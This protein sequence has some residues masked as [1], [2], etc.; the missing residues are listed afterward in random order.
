MPLYAY[1]FTGRYNDELITFHAIAES[2]AEAEQII[3]PSVE[4]YG[5]IEFWNNAVHLMLPARIEFYPYQVHK[6]SVVR[7]LFAFAGGC[8]CMV[9]NGEHE[10]QRCGKVWME[11]GNY[12]NAIIYQ[13]DHFIYPTVQYYFRAGEHSHM[14]CAEDVLDAWHHLMEYDKTL[15]LPSVFR[16]E[17][18]TAFHQD[19]TNLGCLRWSEW[20]NECLKKK[21]GKINWRAH[22]S[23]SGDII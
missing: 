2:L 23:K 8:I 14:E 18:I 20:T 9:K 19:G 17:E 3:Q 10:I 7:G 12:W 15:P 21:Y 1:V 13:D 22:L 16:K 5:N 4:N 6:R 11:V